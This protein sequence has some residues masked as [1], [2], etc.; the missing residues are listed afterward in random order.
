[1]Y[2]GNLS[3]PKTTIF[4]ILCFCTSLISHFPVHPLPEAITFADKGPC[5]Q[6][7]LKPMVSGL[8][9]AQCITKTAVKWIDHTFPLDLK[10]INIMNDV[11]KP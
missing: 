10:F 4:L 8:F 3:N 11:V 9:S 2:T 7:F 6:I 5:K 1:M